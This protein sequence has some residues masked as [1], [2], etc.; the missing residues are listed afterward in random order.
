MRRVVRAKSCDGLIMA[1]YRE[2]HL[3]TK[4]LFI[5]ALILSTAWIMRPFLSA[6]LWATVIVISTWP[7]LLSLQKRLGGRRGLATTVLTVVLLLVLLVP[8]T[9]SV[10]ALVSDPGQAV[11]GS[12]TLRAQIA[13][14]MPGIPVSLQEAFWS[15]PLELVPGTLPATP[16]TAGK[17]N[18]ALLQAASMNGIASHAVLVAGRWPSTSDDTPPGA[19][20]A[21]LPVSAAALLH[22][23]AGDVLRLRDQGTN[24]LVSFD[25]TGVFTRRQGSGAANSYWNLSYIPASG[26]S[27]SYDSSTYGPLVVS[28]A[29]F[30]SAL[31]QQSGSWVAQP[32]M[33]AFQDGSLGPTSASVNVEPSRACVAVKVSSAFRSTSAVRGPNDDFHTS[34]K[35]RTTLSATSSRL[36]S[37]WALCKMLN[38]IG[39]SVAAGLSTMT[40]LRRSSGKR[41]RISSQR[42]DFGSTTTRP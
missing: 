10:S 27:A 41:A 18:T 21:A 25:I 1:K 9:L 14:A 22:V 19:I 36:C 5:G 30:G 12:S 20:P 33:T 40:S 6:L 4:L 39:C 3:T 15:A 24:A 17:G 2:D 29:A 8:L 28:P 35:M 31:T 42:S 16:A 23:S 32:D 34:A 11:Q 38:P 13:A 7:V 37:S 26:V